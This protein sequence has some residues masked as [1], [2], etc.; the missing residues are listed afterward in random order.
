M[1]P[2]IRA[3]EAVR[4]EEWIAE[5][6]DGGARVLIGGERDG[7]LHAP[8]I[9]ADVEPHMRIS[10][11]ELFGPAVAVTPVDGTD[12]AIGVANYGLAAGLFTRD[13]DTAMAFVRSKR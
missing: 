2:M 12:E 8:T 6:V 7:S 1:G 11:E 5:A 10:R 9:V 3:T 4:V 13:L